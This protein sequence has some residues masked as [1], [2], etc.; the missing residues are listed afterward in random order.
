VRL[1]I[2]MV[3][4]SQPKASPIIRAICRPYR[5]YR[6]LSFDFNGFS[7]AWRWTQN[8]PY[9]P[10]LRPYRPLLRPSLKAL[11]LFVMLGVVDD[12]DDV[13]DDFPTQ[14]GSPLMVDDVDAK[15]PPLIGASRKR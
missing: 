8:I 13:D 15:F 3:A 12:V 9:R 11:I 7:M 10:R 6:P 1:S 2:G 14:S 4:R 5:P